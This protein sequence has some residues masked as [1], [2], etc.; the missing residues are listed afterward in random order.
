LW[1]ASGIFIGVRRPGVWISATPS[2]Q[3]PRA[4]TRRLPG[5]VARFPARIEVV[6]REDIRISADTVER[7][8]DGRQAGSVVDFVTLARNSLIE[9]RVVDL[10]ANSNY[11][12]S[13]S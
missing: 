5:R 11:E 3:S 13:F 4:Q 7:V 9:D 2:S 1:S 6:L 10:A 12:G 8:G